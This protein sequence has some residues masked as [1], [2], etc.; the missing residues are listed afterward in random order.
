MSETQIDRFEPKSYEGKPRHLDR[1]EKQLLR[2]L[3]DAM[4]ER[5]AAM[6]DDERAATLSACLNV[7]PVN[8]AWDEYSMAGI[9]FY[10]VSHDVPAQQPGKE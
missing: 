9:A 3:L 8:C 7:S 1:V 5:L 2:S 6:T 4:E 10:S